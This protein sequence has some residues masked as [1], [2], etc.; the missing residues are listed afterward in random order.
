MSSADPMAAAEGE[1]HDQMKTGYWW[2]ELCFWHNPGHVKSMSRFIEPTK[3]WESAET[4]RRIHNLVVVSGLAQQ[5]VSLKGQHATLEDL[6]RVHDLDYIAR[7]KAMSDDETKGHHEAGEGTT[8]SPGAYQVA[9]LAAGGALAAMEAVLTGQVSAAFALTR[10]PGHH[11]ERDEGRGFCIFNNVAICAAAALQKHG[12]QRVA[13]VDYD[14][15]HGNGTQHIFESSNQVLFVSIHQSNNYPPK[16]GYVTETGTGEGV[17]YT[18]NCPLPPGSG[19]GAYKSA[20]ERVVVPALM[21]FQPELILVSSGLDANYQDPLAAMCLSSEDFRA[22]IKTLNE[23]AAKLCGGKLVVLHEGGYSELYSPFCGLAVLEQLSG[24]RTSVQDPYLE[25]VSGWD[26]QEL[27]LHQHMAIG[28]AE[29]VVDLL[30][31][32]CHEHA[33]MRTS[34]EQKAGD[35]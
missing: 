26:Y 3:H 18:I 7:I 32:R 13:I 16:S 25:E 12:L 14:V 9:C 34:A 22:M 4:K 8:F 29:K 1:V 35:A 24:I 20:F 21:A 15:H 17:G 23:S 33:H 11:A 5:L 6:A 31:V 28:K 2:D 27:Q 19:S 30:R 10:P